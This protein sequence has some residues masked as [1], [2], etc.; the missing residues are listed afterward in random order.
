[1]TVVDKSHGKVS[2]LVKPTGSLSAPLILG[3]N[4]P[5][6]STCY[7]DFGLE[8]DPTNQCLQLIGTELGLQH[9]LTSYGKSI[10]WTERV[11]RR[12]RPSSSTRAAEEG[13]SHA[14]NIPAQAETIHTALYKRMW[15]ESLS[16]VG[17][18][19]GLKAW[20][21]FLEIA[22]RKSGYKLFNVKIYDQSLHC[23][24]E[25]D[26]ENKIHRITFC[27]YHPE[28]LLRKKFFCGM[29]PKVRI[30]SMKM[31]D[32]I[33]NFAA[34]F[35]HLQNVKRDLFETIFGA[36]R[37]KAGLENRQRQPRRPRKVLDGDGQEI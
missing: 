8:R 28:F 14:D 37:P 36:L 13:M 34:A 21:R 24:L 27:T 33:F 26:G 29:D 16:K 19:F 1:M 31:V 4:Y 5:T 22:K 11:F 30:D 6:Y 18:V 9:T 23:W 12:Y 35:C 32:D 3:L 7:R 25:R 15:T 20:R 17:I 10:L 2:E